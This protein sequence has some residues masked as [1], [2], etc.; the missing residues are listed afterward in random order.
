MVVFLYLTTVKEKVTV[1][2][3]ES[4]QK[5]MGEFGERKG[6]EEIVKFINNNN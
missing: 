4:R 3:K 6:K 1:N 2:L 5:Y